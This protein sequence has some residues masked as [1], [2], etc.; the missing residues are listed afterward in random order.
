V[1]LLTAIDPSTGKILYETPPVEYKIVPVSVSNLEN[2]RHESRNFQMIDPLFLDLNGDGFGLLNYQQIQGLFDIDNDGNLEQTGW[3]S[4]E[5]GF[6]VLDKN[7]DGIINNS[8]EMFSEYFTEGVTNGFEALKTLDTNNDNIFSADD[9]KF[10]QVQIW[11]D[12]NQ[13][14]QTDSDE[15]F[16]LEQLGITEIALDATLTPGEVLEGNEILA[17]SNYRTHDG[18]ENTVLAVNFIHNPM[19]HQF[20]SD[21]TGT[22]IVS[23]VGFS[24]YVAHDPNGE[25]IDL[26]IKEV[27][28][29]YGGI[30]NDTLIGDA[31]DNWLGGSLGSDTFIGGD[32][33]D[34]MM[35]DSEDRQENINGGDGLDII[36]VVGNKGVYFNLF[37]ANVETAIGGRSSDI[38]IGGGNV[39]AFIRGGAGNDV[40]IGG[41]VDDAL[42]GEDGNDF[43]NGLGGNDL[44]RGHR[45]QDLLIGNDGNDIINGGLDNDVLQ[46][47]KGNDILIGGSGDDLL[48]GGEGF[49]VAEVSGNYHEYILTRNPDGS[50]TITDTIAGRDGTDTGK[51]IHAI[52]FANIK[53][54]EIDIENPLPTNDTV[55]VYG[56][57]PYTILASTILA[58][59]IDYQGDALSIRELLNIR[60]GTAELDNHGNVLFT[61][62]PN[63]NGLM[64]FQYK[65]QDSKGYFGANVNIIGGDENAEM[66]GTVYLRQPEHPTDPLFADQWY[67]TGA[68]VLPVWRDYTGQGINI[69]M[70][71]P[72]V[73]EYTHPD[74]APNV[75]QDWLNSRDLPEDTATHA[76]LV[77]GVIVASR[78]G[79]GSVGVAYNAT[80][81]SYELSIE[82]L[83]HLK[84]FSKYDIANNSW[85][86]EPRFTRNFLKNEP[87]RGAFEKAVVEGRDGLGTVL[88]FVAGN[89]RKEGGNANDISVYSS[90]FTITVGAINAPSDLGALVIGQDPF[91]NPGA[92][93]L[94]SAPGSNVKSTS[95]LLE[96]NN[97][98]TFGNDYEV[99]QGTSFATPLVSGIVALMLEANP[100]L[101]YRDVQEILGYS[102]RTI[103]DPNTDWKYNG[104]NNW[105]GG[106]LH[107]SYDYG[108]GNVDAL[109][110]VRLAETWT[111]TNTWFNEQTLSYISPT[112]N[113]GIPDLG[114]VSDTITVT[115]A[116]DLEYAE[117]IL[118]FNH[119]NLGDLVITLISPDGT[120]SI[121]LNR[122]GKA[123]GSSNEDS[124]DGA[125]ILRHSFSSTN[126][127]GENSLG[128]WTLQITD[129]QG[130][131]VG[132]LNNWILKLYGKEADENDTYIYTNEYANLASGSRSILTDT[133]GTD[134]INAAAIDSN[135]TVNL[136]PG[137]VSHL[138]GQNLTIA[139]N[140]TIE[141]A[142]TGDGDDTLTGNTIDNLLYGGRGNDYINGGAGADILIGAQDNNTLTGGA[143]SDVFVI[144]SDNNATDTITDFASGERIT[145]VGFTEFNSFSEL[146]VTQN[147]TDTLINLGNQQTLII[148]NTVAHS[149][150]AGNFNF[151]DAFD[152]AEDFSG[153]NPHILTPN[154]DSN[155]D[156]FNIIRGD[157]GDN[158]LYGGPGNDIIYGGLGNDT[159]AGDAGDD[160]IYLEGDKDNIFGGAGSDRF[161]FVPNDKSFGFSLGK[162]GLVASNLIWDFDISDSDEKIDL[163]AIEHLTAFEDL[164]LQNF[165]INGSKFTWIYLGQD[166]NQ[167]IALK[168]VHPSELSAD[169][170]VFSE[171]DL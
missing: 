110:A 124:G 71:E 28:S 24:S 26:A 123:P 154:D 153:D 102:A 7:E 33:N 37:Q 45:G 132:T 32:G 148:S 97:G 23:E 93:I 54:V 17:R 146:N 119:E 169:N 91:S 114:K 138:A 13:N 150:S 166:S 34:F 6:L 86:F 51:N 46:G 27:S 108:F 80:L 69:G 149:L 49:N 76:T 30:G 115:D 141:N 1:H 61:P 65:L 67:L 118:D 116:I 101:G 36:Q 83:N 59:D 92:N 78:N 131:N 113:L 122:A 135:T 126:H 15:L 81:A 74:L 40:I 8:S 151:T 152:F 50:I 158:H 164:R 170:F 121:L 87:L 171:L 82:D 159:L 48:D 41:L 5:D 58:N 130:N 134:A 99:A 16:Y 18:Q 85:G 10:S 167:Y 104:A 60:G 66:K 109:A 22:K 100:N 12:I 165:G 147:G 128:D 145:L 62:D 157:S 143:D 117:V 77:A 20:V 98:S 142:F 106:G 52:N 88:V 75:N 25:V 35:I 156:D 133:E 111:G 144:H 63:F 160:I 137:T 112:T 42:S 38:L 68:N 53:E 72:G 162:D 139:S 39:N 94:I 127:W 43:I 2:I 73:F 11:Q 155:H 57:T 168:E 55:D 56:T 14:L 103:N 90:R 89:E 163:S 9:S 136:N 64:S 31:E 125:I 3:V 29:G 95:R 105:N 120:E 19:G 44:I 129:A 4:A 161:V 70:F 21:G 84:Q 96:N 107:T 79:K 140:T 47:E